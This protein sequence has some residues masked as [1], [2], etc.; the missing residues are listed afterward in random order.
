MKN[1]GYYRFSD[2][3]QSTGNSIERQMQTIT[4]FA[5]RRGWGQID[6]WQCGEAESAWTGANRSAGSDLGQFEAEA[7]LGIHTGKRFIVERLD[8]LSRQGY[9]ATYALVR[10][11][12]DNGV[13][14]ATV[15]GDRVYAAY[16]SFE[17]IAVI[18]LLI[19]AEMAAEE[20]EKKS[21]RIRYE[22]TCLR[23]RARDTGLVVS[24]Q[25]PA[26][27]EKGPDGR[28]RVIEGRDELV[29]QVFALADGGSGSRSIVN[30]LNENFPD[31]WQPRNSM[32]A[33]Y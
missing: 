14:V 6:E 17:K 11:L 18:D 32:K 3:K 22:L 30:Y 4:D 8:R 20:S 16:Q 26:W 21:Q 33:K 31:C 27:L 2:A 12:T 9:D 15:D 23:E 28:A 5:A 24:S 25:L 1:I 29:R 19:K 10:M 7:K 13:E